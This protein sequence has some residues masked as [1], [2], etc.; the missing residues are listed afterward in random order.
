MKTEI[1]APMA[2]CLAMAH[3]HGGKLVRYIG[4]YWSWE[5]A[6][7]HQHNG[8]PVEYAGTSTV[9]GLVKRGRLKYTEWKEGRGGKFPI[10][11][12]LIGDD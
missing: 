7:K 9:E 2:I 11:A 5:H 4:G 10:A 1:S 3:D 6:P 12:E 8:N